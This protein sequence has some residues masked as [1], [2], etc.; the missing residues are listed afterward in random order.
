MIDMRHLL[1]FHEVAEELHFGRTAARLCVA[2]PA[3][4]RQ[5]EPEV[6]GKGRSSQWPQE[7]THSMGDD[8]QEV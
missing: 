4:S 7:R 3:L 5:N 2:Q 8:D 6:P 1:H